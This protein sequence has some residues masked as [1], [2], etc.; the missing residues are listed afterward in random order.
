MRLGESTRELSIHVPHVSCLRSL[1]FN[2]QVLLG[3]DLESVVRNWILLQS[4]GPIVLDRDDKFIAS[5]IV[6]RLVQV[7]LMINIIGRLC[8]YLSIHIIFVDR[9]SDHGLNKN[10]GGPAGLRD[11]RMEVGLYRE[12]EVSVLGW[13]RNLISHLLAQIVIL[14]IPVIRVALII[15]VMSNLIVTEAGKEGC[16]VN[17]EDTRC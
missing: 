11:C 12:I 17:E 6:G 14:V 1:F 15:S 4:I 10:S 5:S 9:P 2:F 13:H 8:E 16:S 7:W 3:V